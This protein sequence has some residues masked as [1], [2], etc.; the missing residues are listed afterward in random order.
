MFRAF[1]VFPLSRWQV[2]AAM[3]LDLQAPRLAVDTAKKT[4]QGVAELGCERTLGLGLV[5][6]CK[7][8]TSPSHFR[9]SII[10]AAD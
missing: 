3:D 6:I 8:D 1:L 2:L 7:W 4:I 9:W 10:F 5:Y